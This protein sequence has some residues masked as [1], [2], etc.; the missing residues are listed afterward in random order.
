V[1]TQANPTCINIL[2][3]YAYIV[4]SASLHP[5]DFIKQYDFHTTGVQ[6]ETDAPQSASI[7]HGDPHDVACHTAGSPVQPHEVLQDPHRSRNSEDEHQRECRP[8]HLVPLP[9][10]HLLISQL[11][12][13][14][15]RSGIWSCP[16]NIEDCQVPYGS[17]K[18]LYTVL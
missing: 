1:D 9:C 2:Y 8:Q 16:L 3:P 17:S 13:S 10:H 14:P 4:A 15:T 5:L 6:V 11:R 12:L 18:A 7:D